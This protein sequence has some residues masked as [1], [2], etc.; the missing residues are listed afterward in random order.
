METVKRVNTLGLNPKNSK[1]WTCEASGIGLAPGEWPAVLLFDCG[2]R[3]PPVRFER[4]LQV[5]AAS[6]EFAGVRY[7]TPASA[8][9]R[10]VLTVF[11]D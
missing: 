5:Y 11:N 3:L 2:D 4:G 7:L 6:G 9:K 1:H 8:G 10:T